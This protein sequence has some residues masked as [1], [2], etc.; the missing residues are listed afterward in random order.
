MASV[1]QLRSIASIS[2]TGVLQ[3]RSSTVYRLQHHSNGSTFG[4]CLMIFYG[5]DILK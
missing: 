5:G 1:Q 3:E 2:A 4:R